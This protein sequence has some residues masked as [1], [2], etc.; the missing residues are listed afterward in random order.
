MISAALAF[1]T[2]TASGLA[3]QC[4]A[5]GPVDQSQILKTPRG[6]VDAFDILA[7]AVEIGAGTNLG[8][9]ATGRIDQL[10]SE[11]A[12]AGIR[13]IGYAIQIGVSAGDLDPAYSMQRQDR[14]RSRQ[15]QLRAAEGWQRGQQRNYLERGDD[16]HLAV[17]IRILQA[18]GQGR[19]IVQTQAGQIDIS[20]AQGRRPD[21]GLQRAALL[22]IDQ[23]RGQR[24]QRRG[25]GLGIGEGIETEHLET[26]IIGR[27]YKQAPGAVDHDIGRNA[28]LAASLPERTDVGQQPCIAIEDLDLPGETVSDVDAPDAVDR[29]S[30]RRQQRTAA[31]E[32]TAG[33]GRAAAYA[34]LE[35]TVRI[36]QLHAVAELVGYQQL[37]T[38]GIEKQAGRK[39]ELGVALA[40]GTDVEQPGA[41]G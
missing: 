34:K 1:T 14:G 7:V 39:Q 35:D 27:R 10:T 28:Q 15:H 16:L 9:G 38:R 3:L 17:A 5:F 29:Q 18:S 30:L 22:G 12:R 25:E 24:Q 20:Q 37:I 41:G 2:V 4:L 33:I 13:I 11:G 40:L 21:D 32:E 19:D 23:G 6:P 26:R 31:L 8:H 36:E